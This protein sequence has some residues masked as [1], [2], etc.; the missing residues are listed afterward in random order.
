MPCD[1]SV[2]EWLAGCFD[3]SNV[4]RCVDGPVLFGPRPP[5]WKRAPMA[6]RISKVYL[7]SDHAGI[8][9]RKTVASHLEVAG[10][11][12]EDLGP[13]AGMSVDYPDYGAKL[14]RAMRGDAAARGIAVCG[15]G[16]GISMAVNRFSWCRAALVGDA[17]AA[18]LCREHN[19]ANVLA[20]GQRLTG[21]TVAIDCVDAF[22]ATEFEGGR[23]GGRVEK[24]S[25]LGD[26]ES[27]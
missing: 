1:L 20:L 5:V 16:I 15:S 27:K 24:L 25:S 14:A 13:D 19:D 9:L 21:Q 26:G 22:M 6:G 3:D 23:H 4:S 7:S 8:E 17:T 18:R 2:T 12:V 10:Y 11:V